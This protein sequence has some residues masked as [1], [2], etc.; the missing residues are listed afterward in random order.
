MSAQQQRPRLAFHA[1]MKPPDHPTPSGD[2]QIARLTMRALTEA[3][4]EVTLSSRL[5]SLDMTGDA[6]VQN[7]LQREADAEV[8]RILATPGPRP[9]LWFTYHCYWKAP[10]LVGP[11][12]ARGLGIPYVIS[13]PSLSPRRHEGPWARFAEAAAAAIRQADCLLWTTQR[14]RPALEAAGL[15]RRMIELPAFIDTG[16]APLP[17]AAGTPLR[18]LAV[19]MMREGDKLESYCRLGAAL[20]ALDAITPAWRLDVIGDGPARGEVAALLAPFAERVTLLG[21]RD[22]PVEIRAAMEG[23]DLLVWPGV[24]EGVGLVWL[25]AQAAGL[26]PIAEDGPAARAVIA[27]EM[28]PLPPPGDAAAFA[29]AIHRAS[30]RRAARSEAV[31]RHAEARHSLDA[32]ATRLRA[33]LM[34]LI[35]PST[36]DPKGG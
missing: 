3:G 27:P 9:Q 17:R 10:D 12:V 24:A 35:A 33:A 36:P 2:R 26:P 30:A 11:A 7:S 16:A 5:R 22:D 18:L 15:T 31:R 4:F 28:Q 32:A 21:I 14:D 25:E 29:K 34:P 6:A 1:P 20:A 8:E 13:E 23:A 19:A